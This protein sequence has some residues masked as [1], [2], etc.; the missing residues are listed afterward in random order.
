LPLLEPTNT[1]LFT[2][3]GAVTRGPSPLNVQVCTRSL[4]RVEDKVPALSAMT[5]VLVTAGA[6][7]ETPSEWF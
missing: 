4:R 7:D 6:S 3:T 5:V 1:V 2:T